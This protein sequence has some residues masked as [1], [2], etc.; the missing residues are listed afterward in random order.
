MKKSLESLLRKIYSTAD[1]VTR[2]EMENEYPELFQS[3][4]EFK[5]PLIIDKYFG[6]KGDTHPFVIAYGMA[7]RSSLQNKCLLVNSAYKAEIFEADGQQ[8]IKLIK[9]Y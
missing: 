6:N 8:F 3:L 1:E 2:C 4:Y 5:E 7:P 9:K